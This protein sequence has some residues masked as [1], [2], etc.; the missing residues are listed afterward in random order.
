MLFI[1]FSLRF[2][3]CCYLIALSVLAFLQ[4]AFR[5]YF[6]GIL[7]FNLFY[8]SLSAFYR[9]YFA[10]VFRALEV[11]HL[12]F[13]PSWPMFFIAFFIAFKAGFH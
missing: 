6:T 2:Y 12:V 1:V 9:F 3:V 5:F 11:D 8:S 13:V 10:S 7:I 4:L